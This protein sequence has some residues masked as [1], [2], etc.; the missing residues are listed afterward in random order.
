MGLASRK[1]ITVYML[2]IHIVCLLLCESKGIHD[3]RIFRSAQD[4]FTN[5][6]CT[7]EICKRTQC[8]SYGAECV[9]DHDNCT[10]CRCSEGKNT[11]MINEDNQRKGECKSDEEIVPESGNALDQ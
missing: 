7:G 10:Y 1:G 4:I 3:F 11:F 2:C 6:N 9:S 5:L 8:E